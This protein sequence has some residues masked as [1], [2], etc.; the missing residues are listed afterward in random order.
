MNTEQR[1]A[2]VDLRTE[3]VDLSTWFTRT[4]TVHIYHRCFIPAHHESWYSFYLITSGGL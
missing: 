4:D 2:G 3:S 1:R